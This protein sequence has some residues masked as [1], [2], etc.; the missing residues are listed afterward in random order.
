MEDGR[1]IR[2]RCLCGEITFHLVPPTDFVSHC[3]CQSCRLSHGAAFV[4]WTSVPRERFVLE[5]DDAVKWYRSSPQIEWGF[6]P[7]CG[8]SLLYRAIADGHHESP[9]RD[10]IYVAAGSLI[11]PLDRTVQAHVSFEE[12]VHWYECDDSLPRYRGK[13]LEKI[14]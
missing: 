8:S 1:V 12:R 14:G 13:G 10:R 6:C 9:K 4:T 2:G 5:R 7:A 3:H 11:D